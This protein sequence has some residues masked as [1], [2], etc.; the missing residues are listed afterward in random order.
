MILN[1]FLL[2]STAIIIVHVDLYWFKLPQ[3]VSVLS[4]FKL[5]LTFLFHPFPHFRCSSTKTACLWSFAALFMSFG[6]IYGNCSGG[7]FFFISTGTAGIILDIPRTICGVWLISNTRPSGLDRQ[8]WRMS[9][10]FG[11][12]R[13]CIYPL[14]SRTTAYRPIVASAKRR[15]MKIYWF[16]K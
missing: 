11:M 7:S 13:N 4:I 10:S 8:S 12:Y 15:K 1:S 3:S 5:H 14:S 2:F 9:T 16:F 6:R